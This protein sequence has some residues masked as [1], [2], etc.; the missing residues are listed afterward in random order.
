ML[1]NAADAGSGLAA[2][3]EHAGGAS[4][5]PEGPERS[6]ALLQLV[7]RVDW[8]FLLPTATLQR[9]LFVGPN[10]SLH[11]QAIRQVAQAL[12]TVETAA[13]C[14]HACADKNYDVVVLTTPPAGE[15]KYVSPCLAPGGFLYCEIARR[16]GMPLGWLRHTPRSYARQAAALGFEEIRLCWHRPDF[17]ACREMIPLDRPEVLAFVFSRW[18]AGWLGWLQ[19]LA[20]WLIWKTGLLNAVVPAFSLLARKGGKIPV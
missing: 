8:R 10:D 1:D 12:D 9:V 7:R 18:K 13:C 17:P 5:G 19:S 15:M 11:Q 6:D 3:Q 16:P 2:R 20:G 4:P 14:T